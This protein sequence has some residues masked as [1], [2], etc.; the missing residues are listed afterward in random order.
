[1]AHL[2]MQQRHD[3]GPHTAL[4]NDLGLRELGVGNLRRCKVCG[5]RTVDRMLKVLLLRGSKVRLLASEAEA[6]GAIH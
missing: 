5:L 6:Q 1:M 3:A 2:R 4:L